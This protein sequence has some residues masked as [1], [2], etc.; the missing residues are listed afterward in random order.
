[1]LLKLSNPGFGLTITETLRYVCQC[2]FLLPSL[3]FFR[4][5]AQ[6]KLPV[7]LC[8]YRN[9]QKRAL[10]KM[11]ASPSDLDFFELCARNEHSKAI[12]ELNSFLQDQQKISPS[13]EQSKLLS[14][15]KQDDATD[16]IGTLHSPQWRAEIY[17][18][19]ALYYQNRLVQVLLR[20]CWYR[21]TYHP[22][23]QRQD[24]PPLSSEVLGMLAAVRW[25]GS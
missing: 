5:L 11:E 22:P 25:K 2:T 12:K 17:K 24:R 3:T 14:L 4:F 9:Q 10:W 18:A 20:I 16:L 21:E 8:Y 23:Q 6:I 19:Y 13:P 1:M 7:I 15:L